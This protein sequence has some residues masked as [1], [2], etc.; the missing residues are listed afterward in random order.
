VTRD[1]PEG[2]ALLD[3][4]SA[5]LAEE[6]PE[7][8]TIRRIAGR[9][10][11]STM[12]VYSRLGGK[13]G[14]VEALL[15]EGF[16]RLTKVLRSVRATA[17]PLVDLRRCSRAYRK[18]ALDNPTYYAVMFERAVP[19]T[20]WTSEAGAVAAATLGV[21][22]ERVQRAMDAG[23]LVPGPAIEVAACLWAANHGCVSLELKQIG[24]AEINWSKRYV[25]IGD[26]ILTGLGTTR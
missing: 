25:Q 17:D 4:A 20:A 2:S 18:F 21:L 10:G 1:T 9:A 7:A 8:L 12:L 16:E 19:D 14:I 11:C 5:L 23:A 26:A 13:A 24:P 6:G 22:A 3:A 15:T